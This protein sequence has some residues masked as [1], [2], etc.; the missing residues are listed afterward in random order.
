MKF[1][2][3]QFIISMQ[4]HPLAMHEMLNKDDDDDEWLGSRHQ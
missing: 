1:N 3:S 4:L 2:K